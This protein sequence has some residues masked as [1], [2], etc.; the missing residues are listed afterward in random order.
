M[1]L[2]SSTVAELENL[3]R[4]TWL[5][6]SYWLVFL[7]LLRSQKT[8]ISEARKDIR[9]LAVEI[10]EARLLEEDPLQGVL[11]KYAQIEEEIT[12]DVVRRSQ[13]IS[14]LVSPFC[15]IFRLHLTAYRH[16]TSLECEMQNPPRSKP[17]QH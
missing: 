14:N 5:D 8:S 10:K 11:D 16:T 1:A 12:G 4:E 6:S 2:K 17:I 9:A 15:S 7:K 3:A 13:N